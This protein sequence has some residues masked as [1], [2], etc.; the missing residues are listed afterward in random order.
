MSRVAVEEQEVVP[1][2][3]RTTMLEVSKEMQ[4]AR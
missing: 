3:V 4:T 1:C 2:R